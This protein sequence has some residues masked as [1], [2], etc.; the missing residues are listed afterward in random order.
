MNYDLSSVVT[1]TVTYYSRAP[2]SDGTL[3]SCGAIYPPPQERSHPW[4]LKK[5]CF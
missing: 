4:V 2:S 5:G 1:V 3:F